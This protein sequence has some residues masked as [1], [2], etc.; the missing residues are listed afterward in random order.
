MSRGLRFIRCDEVLNMVGFSHSTL[1][2]Y[3]GEGLFPP[4]IHLSPKMVGWDLWEVEEF[5]KAR[6]V[7]WSNDEI[8]ALVL[9]LVAERKPPALGDC[10]KH[11]PHDAPQQIEEQK[12]RT[13]HLLLQAATVR[14]RSLLQQKFLGRLEQ[15]ID[16]LEMPRQE[17]LED[18]GLTPFR[19]PTLVSETFAKISASIMGMAEN[20]S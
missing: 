12:P 3:M 18:W 5:M 16:E 1:Y 2:D 20:P 13:M 7:G 9:R 10:G 19:T 8:R 6:R 17:T 15:Y 11:V 4:Q 14:A